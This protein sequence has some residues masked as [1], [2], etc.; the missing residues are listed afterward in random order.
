[1]VVRLEG[2]AVGAAVVGCRRVGQVRGGS[3]QTA[4][5]WA[6]DDAVGERVVVRIRGLER[7]SCGVVRTEGLALGGRRVVEGLGRDVD[8]GNVAE[9]A[10]GIH[11]DVVEAVRADVTGGGCVFHAE[12]GCERERAVRRA[13]YGEEHG[14]AFRVQGGRR[15]DDAGIL[16]ERGGR[17]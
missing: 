13:G 2:E 10:V 14:I 12:V 3:G 4:V 1:A 5:A 9:R 16:I 6:G 15:D 17:A 8:G 7:D 11:E